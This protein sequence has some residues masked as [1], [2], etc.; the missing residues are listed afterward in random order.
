MGGGSLGLWKAQR[1][2]TSRQTRIETT[3]HRRT[4]R[5]GVP[6]RTSFSLPRRLLLLSSFQAPGAQDQGAPPRRAS[7]ARREAL[8]Q[9]LLRVPDL[10]QGLL[11]RRPRE[12]WHGHLPHAVANQPCLKVAS[13]PGAGTWD[14]LPSKPRQT[15]LP[16]GSLSLERS[17]TLR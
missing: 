4:T 17:R 7:H 12:P 15:G 10:R 2:R 11:D 6:S 14:A 13:E 9:V 8:L 16:V 5:D 3:D 1:L